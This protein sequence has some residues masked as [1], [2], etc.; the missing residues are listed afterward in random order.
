MPSFFDW[1]NPMSKKNPLNQ[2]AF[3]TPEK[4]KNVSNLRPEQEGLYNQL[5]QAGQQPGAGG[6][7]GQSADY[8]RG[9]LGDNGAD[10]NA[11]AN[12]QLRQYYQDIV[13]NISEQFGGGGG[14]QGSFSSS[15]FRNAQ[16]Q[17]SV[18]LAERLGQIRANL[19]QAGAQGLQNIGQLGLQNF[20]Q[21]MVTQPGSS[22]F[23]S[24]VAPA[25]G[26]AIGTAIGGP[27]GGAIG[28][29]AGGL[30][31]GAGGNQVGMN[32]GPYQSSNI[33]ASPQSNNPASIPRRSFNSYGGY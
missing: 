21:N 7:F 13:P 20:S 10:F 28:A 18:D 11:F 23:L 12:P 32:R 27:V 25:I 26:G 31:G 3:G 19:R 16:V 24:S 2:Y 5:I 6:A 15:G 29:G 4:R 30:F 9:L 33:P 22:G 17:G 1:I 14:G 8:Y